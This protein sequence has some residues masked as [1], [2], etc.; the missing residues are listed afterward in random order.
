V[1]RA[2]T[3]G[4]SQAYLDAAIRLDQKYA[5]GDINRMAHLVD[6]ALRWSH[7]PRRADQ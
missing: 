3:T 2:G 7:G 1:P 4:Q 6:E 5:A